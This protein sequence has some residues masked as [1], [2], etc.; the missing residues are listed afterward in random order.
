MKCRACGVDVTPDSVFCQ[1]CG[2]RLS[3]EPHP[4]GPNS[5]T[6]PISGSRADINEPEQEL[7]QGGFSGKAM[8][9]SWIVAAIVSVVLI[10]AA[11]FVWPV[12]IAI[13]IIWA[14]LGAYLLYRKLG[15]HYTLTSQRFIHQSG[16]LV[17]TTDRVEIIEIDDVT[18]SQGLVERMIGV[19]TIKISSSDK[20]H[21]EILLLGIDDVQRVSGLIDDTRR[22]ERRRRGVFMEQ[23]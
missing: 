4:V 19:G 3:G 16:I 14:G 13:P 7:W 15:V 22:K 12:V 21:P 17:R 23:I 9:G 18:F 1:K 10:V 6:S 11:F 5:M 20:T 8:Y 2:A